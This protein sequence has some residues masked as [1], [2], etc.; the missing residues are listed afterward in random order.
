M[1]VT[2]VPPISISSRT[3]PSQRSLPP[4]SLVT[5]FEAPVERRGTGNK[6]AGLFGHPTGGLPG[7]KKYIFKMSNPHL[8]QWKCRGLRANYPELQRIMLKHNVAAAC[9]QETKLP[10]NL[11]FNIRGLSAYHH[12]SGGADGLSG[13]S[14]FLLLNDG[15]PSYCH[16]ANGTFSALDLTFIDPSLSLDYSWSTFDSIHGSDHFPILL[17]PVRSETISHQKRWNFTLADWPAFQYQCL[18][19]ISDQKISSIEQFSDAVLL[20]AK[21]TIPQTST[22]PRKDKP[23]FDCRCRLAVRAGE[24]AFNEFKGNASL[25]TLN[26]F[27]KRRAEAR[28][29]IRQQKRQSWKNFI[30]KVNKDTPLSKVW[31]LVRKIQGKT[32]AS[33]VKHLGEADGS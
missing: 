8:L 2:N 28:R 23:W 24:K 1:E 16:P 9:L 27:K 15:S 12:H 13:E 3:A 6:P 30:S 25:E 29:S 11:D 26:I 19:E 33:A 10:P 32:V 21:R 20:I 5:I 31:K 7:S 14:D 22:V 4:S 17:S 18:L